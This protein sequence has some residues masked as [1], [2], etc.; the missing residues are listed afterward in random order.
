[1]LILLGAFFLLAALMTAL[2]P[3]PAVPVNLRRGWR[4]M[5]VL[6]ALFAAGYLAVFLLRLESPSLPVE[7]FTRIILSGGG[8]FVLLVTA[9]MRRSFQGLSAGEEGL[10]RANRALRE[11]NQQLQQEIDERKHMEDELIGYRTQLQELVQER[12]RE[13]QEANEKLI[14]EANKL[15]A[16]LAALGDGLTLQDTDFRIL[17][18]NAPHKEKQGDHTGELCYQAYQHRDTVCPECQLAKCF[19]D[20]R[21]HR[22]EAKAETAEG[23]IHMEVSASPLR[24]AKSRIIGGVEVIRD[25][26][27]RKLL[28]AQL[29]QAQKME[30]IGSLAGGIAHDFNNLLTTIIGYS[31]LSLMKVPGGEPLSENLTAILAAGKRAASLTRQLLAFSRKQVLEMKIIDLNEVVGGMAKMLSRLIGERI[32]LKVFVEAKQPR[33]LAD[34]TQVEQI[35][36]NLAINA[37]DAMP[38]GGSLIIETADTLLDEKYARRHQGV[39]PGSYVM[40]SVTDTGEGIP[41]SIREKIFEPFFTTKGMGQGT[42]LGLATV[43]GIVKQHKG[44]IYLYSEPGKG[45]TFKVYLPAAAGEPESAT[46]ARLPGMPGGRETILVVDDESSIRSLIADTLRPLGYRLLTAANGAE[47]LAVARETEGA[48]DLL[49][50]DVVMKGMNGRE[51]AESMIQERPEM[52]VLYMSGYTDNVIAH[53]GVLKPGITLLDKPLTPSLLASRIRE[54]LDS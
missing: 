10:D 14:G 15:E 43:F 26:S 2:R 52:K 6:I 49:L 7:V 23:T 1:M 11:K 54:V 28:E 34:R 24:D 48:I 16:V 38:E 5:T 39:E 19:E 45:T 27:D 20:G 47:A 18:Q 41:E 40:L 4:L 13:L 29:R 37:R 50:T 22:R 51:L 31:E 32:E 3:G 33:T 42:G 44:H 53:Q 30:A 17:Y 25:I 8:F 46:A 21:V 9:L 35:V 12:T 36:M